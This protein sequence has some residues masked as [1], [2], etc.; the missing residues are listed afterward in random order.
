MTTKANTLDALKSLLQKSKVGDCFIFTV[1]NWNKQSKSLLD[2][3][4]S[5]FVDSRLAIRS[6]C[7]FEDGWD[8]SKAGLFETVLGVDANSR[9]NVANAIEKVIYSYGKKPLNNHQ[10]LIQKLVEE[11]EFSGVIFTCSLA[12]GAPYYHINFDDQRAITNSVTSG[13]YNELRTI[14]V[15]RDSVNDFRRKEPKLSP[16]LDAIIEIE[17]L[18]ENKKLDLEFAVDVHG[19]VHL[20][21]VRPI[22]LKHSEYGQSNSQYKACISDNVKYFQ[23][24][25]GTSQNLHGKRTVF[26]NMPDWNPAEMLGT[27]PKPFAMSLYRFLIT[28]SVWA[29]Q[30]A[31]FGYRD[32]RPSK[33]VYEFGNRP[34]VDLRASLN[35]FIPREVSEEA[36]ER[37]VNAY[38]RFFIDH[39]HLHD[40]IEFEV[41]LTAWVPNLIDLASDR[42]IPYGVRKSDL[43]E[44]DIALKKVSRRSIESGKQFIAPIK[45][46]SKYRKKII[47]SDLPKVNK[48]LLLLEDCKQY[49]TISF[50]HSARLAF[51]SIAVLKRLVTM[52][53]MSD[54]R[55]T[56]FLA[57]T[58][59]I[60]TQFISRKNEF[61]GQ[62]EHLEGLIKD[63]G[64]LRPGTYELDSEAYWENPSR[65]FSKTVLIQD[66]AEEKFD[67][68]EDEKYM[69]NNYLVEIGS[70]LSVNQFIS[71]IKATIVWR[72]E[73]KFEFTKNVSKALDLTVELALE[74]G[75]TREQSSYL[76]VDD[77]QQFRRKKI[78]KDHI[79]EN[80]NEREERWNFTRTIELPQVITDETCFYFFEKSKDQ[81]N[82]ITLKKIRGPALCCDDTSM[83]TVT[84]HI[85]LIEKADPG[86][87]WLISSGISGLI[88]KYG[89]ANS[90]MA[91][92]AAEMGIPAAIGVGEALYAHLIKFCNLELDCENQIIRE[93]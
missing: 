86:Y 10:I 6:S 70:K 84:G 17:I 68:T 88:T 73:L 43:N 25:Q 60:T 78:S 28:D 20:F 82:F 53:S 21:Q 8:S 9:I 75:F 49:G 37:I 18:L 44:L 87:D 2:N 61:N 93:G 91:I 64:H 90:H 39:Q 54:K 57:N 46:L 3:I 19:V 45:K 62:Q 67:F 30:R 51:I 33:L 26:A 1:D 48:I 85:V 47:D 74:L 79:L 14:T 31:E 81:P 29:Q 38:L 4:Q 22:T 16:V 83:S 27:H 35:S 36:A 59:N 15:F 76:T 63:Y 77:L 7:I 69:L 55:F 65:F 34:Y 66:I 5:Q 13:N 50:A 89:G 58:K 71:H 72:E 32:V 41:A 12:T 80:I 92:R 40:K 11:I 52:G 24:I 23:E 42:L 56:D